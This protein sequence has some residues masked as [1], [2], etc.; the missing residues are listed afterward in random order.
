VHQPPR[1]IEGRISPVAGAP[2]L[3]IITL[4]LG[5]TIWKPLRVRPFSEFH[6]V[7][8]GDLPHVPVLGDTPFTNAYAAVRT[9]DMSN[10]LEWIHHS[11]PRPL[12]RMTT[13]TDHGESCR[14]D[15]HATT[16]TIAQSIRAHE[17]EEPSTAPASAGTD[18]GSTPPPCSCRRSIEKRLCDDDH[19]DDVFFEYTV[20]HIRRRKN[21]HPEVGP[22]RSRRGHVR[23]TWHDGKGQP[24]DLAEQRNKEHHHGTA[25]LNTGTTRRGTGEG[26]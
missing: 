20:G 7:K 12:P 3:A 18:V 19:P 2:K 9:G 10:E 25:C 11:P 5:T 17:S 22:N 1:R 8:A 23:S 4:R 13:M 26:R 24:D 15:T 14:T 21:S 6:A 16:D